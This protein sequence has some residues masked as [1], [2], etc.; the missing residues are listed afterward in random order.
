MA[1]MDLEGQEPVARLTF[2][3]ARPFFVAR[4]ARYTSGS[5]SVLAS[6]VSNRV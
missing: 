3:Q 5:K 2:L 4:T 1:S 6:L